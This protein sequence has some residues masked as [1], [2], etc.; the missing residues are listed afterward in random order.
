MK[1]NKFFGISVILFSF[2]ILSCSTFSQS[3]RDI[4]GNGDT[5]SSIGGLV[6]P[7]TFDQLVNS[8]QQAT[9]ARDSSGWGIYA[10]SIRYDL[11][12]SLFGFGSGNGSA[13]AYSLKDK[14]FYDVRA[15]DSRRLDGATKEITLRNVE[16]GQIL[17][18][19]FGASEYESQGR[20]RAAWGETFNLI[21]NDAQHTVSLSFGPAFS[22]QG[23][24]RQRLKSMNLTNEELRINYLP[25]A[26]DF[27][28]NV[29]YIYRMKF[30]QTLDSDLT[31]CQSED[32]KNCKVVAIYSGGRPVQPGDKK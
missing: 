2:T 18:I 25:A 4:A 8:I 16:A 13:K 11:R 27:L 17:E 31:L 3:P 21:K 24:L 28:Q 23:S 10:M 9:S 29:T 5:S 19:S 7:Q 32:F 12:S 6:Q 14:V 15:Q 30:N 20:Q 26:N 1:L 22:E